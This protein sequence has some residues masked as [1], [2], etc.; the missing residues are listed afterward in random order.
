MDWE[1][2]AAAVLALALI[3]VPIG[4][5]TFACRNHEPKEH[6]PTE[7]EQYPDEHLFI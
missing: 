6:K 3:G 5:L 7:R 2:A 4:L 1:P